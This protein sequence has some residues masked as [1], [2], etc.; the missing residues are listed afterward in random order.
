[1]LEVTLEVMFGAMLGFMLESNFSL[2]G[3]YGV[4]N[5]NKSMLEMTL[6]MTFGTVLGF[7]LES[8]FLAV[9]SAQHL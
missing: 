2:G 4:L 7:M 8:H 1:M 9:V 5:G 3:F 6:E